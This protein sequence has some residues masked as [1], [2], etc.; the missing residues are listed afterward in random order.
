MDDSFDIQVTNVLGRQV[1][2]VFNRNYGFIFSGGKHIS[3]S[4]NE[5]YMDLPIDVLCEV[6]KKYME[7]KLVGGGK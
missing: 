1:I 3:I 5:Q 4:I 2:S 7:P 6:L